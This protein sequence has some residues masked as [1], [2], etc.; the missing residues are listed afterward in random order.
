MQSEQGKVT[1]APNLQKPKRGAKGS[2]SLR[3]EHPL[4]AAERLVQGKQ[5]CLF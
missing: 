2:W 5:L 3:D 1:G 4:L